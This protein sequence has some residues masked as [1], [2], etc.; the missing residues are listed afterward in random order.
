MVPLFENL[1]QYC[2]I[3]EEDYSNGWTIS[4]LPESCE[5]LLDEYCDPPANATMP[6]STVLP[7]T[8]SPAYYISSSSPTT[9]SSTSISVSTAPEQ[10]GIAANCKWRSRSRIGPGLGHDH[11]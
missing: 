4:D 7:A 11:D 10:T 5:D 2:P 1:T 9:A 3:T 6:A 8:C